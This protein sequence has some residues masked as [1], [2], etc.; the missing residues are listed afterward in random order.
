MEKG[1]SKI[2]LSEA[3]LEVKSNKED[4][5][6]MV[7]N[8]E[9]AVV[10]AEDKF[11]AIGRDLSSLFQEELVGLTLDFDR[12]KI[13]SG[14]GLMFE[15]PGDDPDEPDQVKE[16]I[17]VI[18]DHYPINAYWRDKYSGLSNPPDCSSMDGIVGIDIEGKAHQCSTCS[19]NQWG[20]DENGTGKACKNMHR[21]Y[22]LREG[23]LFPIMLTLPPTSI[24]NFSNYLA[25][26]VIGRGK[27]SCEV[28]TKIALKKTMNKS[29]ISY[30]QAVFT[31]VEVLDEATAEKLWKYSEGIK[32]ITRGVKIDNSEARLVEED[33]I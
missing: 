29:G 14:G 3:E 23:D 32:S 13:P 18:V 21:I 26:R 8:K 4:D 30:S 19:F 5:N 10:K 6:N 24:K 20:S 25:K 15:V 33:I 12:V 16:L 11:P 9:Q 31:L 1:K 2:V 22:L 28:V 7:E 27:R 17:G